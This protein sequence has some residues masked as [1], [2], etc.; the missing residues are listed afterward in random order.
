MSDEKMPGRT[1]PREPREVTYSTFFRTYSDARLLTTHRIAKAMLRPFFRD[2]RLMQAL[3]K[4]CQR[5]ELL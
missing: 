5:R 2:P 3:R 4:E 1:T